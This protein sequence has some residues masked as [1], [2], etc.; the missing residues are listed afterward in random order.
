[1]TTVPFGAWTVNHSQSKRDVN[2]KYQMWEW[3]RDSVSNGW[4]GIFHCWTKWQ[5]ESSFKLSLDGWRNR[6]EGWFSLK[7]QAQENVSLYVKEIPRSC[8][9]FLSSPH[10]LFHW[11]ASMN[12]II[13]CLIKKLLLHKLK[14][15]LKEYWI[16]WISTNFTCRTFFTVDWIFFE[17]CLRKL[18]E[19]CFCASSISTN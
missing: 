7:Y 14:N 3:R 1:M 11:K 2:Y 18:S 10:P 6:M 12:I 9:A 5:T 15:L 13:K 4:K 16:F 19:S 8:V 17:F